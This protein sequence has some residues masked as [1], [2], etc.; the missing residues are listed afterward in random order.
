VHP[1]EG[2][3]LKAI[4][5]PRLPY[6]KRAR[7]GLCQIDSTNPPSTGGGVKILVELDRGTPETLVDARSPSVGRNQGSDTRTLLFYRRPI[8]TAKGVLDEMVKATVTYDNFTDPIATIAPVTG[9]TLPNQ[10]SLQGSHA[11]QYGSFSV[12]RMAVLRLLSSGTVGVVGPSVDLS[13]PQRFARHARV[14][15]GPAGNFIAVWR[16]NHLGGLEGR[17]V[18][19]D[20]RFS[21]GEVTRMAGQP[22]GAA[23]EVT[24]SDRGILLPDEHTSWRAQAVT[25]PGG[26]ATV[27]WVNKRSDVDQDDIMLRPYLGLPAAEWPGGPP[28]GD[29]GENL[30]DVTPDLGTVCPVRE[31]DSPDAPVDW[32][33]GSADLGVPGEFVI[34]SPQPIIIDVP[35]HPASQL[36]IDFGS[37]IGDVTTGGQVSMRGDA[38]VTWSFSALPVIDVQFDTSYLSVPVDPGA[39]EQFCTADDASSGIEAVMLGSPVDGNGDAVLV[40]HLEIP[41]ALDAPVDHALFRIPLSFSS[42]MLNCGNALVESPETCDDGNHVATDGC[43]SRCQVEGGWSCTGEPSTC[44]EICGD[45]IPTPSES[46]DD[47]NTADGDCCSSSC[48]HEASGSPCADEDVCNGEEVC[49]GNG[50]CVAGSSLD[51]D[52]GEPCT[53]DSCDPVQG[54]SNTWITGCGEAI[55]TLSAW[56]YLTLLLLVAL[57]AIAILI[58]RGYTG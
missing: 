57:A 30:D 56:G 4:A 14:A 40:G 19:G 6:Q 58:R 49:N 7:Q 50:T 55:P 53:N 37:L 29:D 23:A 54:C 27:M 8:G 44:T 11:V 20:I 26:S 45:G 48:Q 21:M 12:V 51:C 17:L 5:R 34:T 43:D 38:S 24:V 9:F 13:L 39:D 28:F 46:C 15:T 2:I 52:D 31:G 3:P 36:Q 35:D 33:P 25:N 47:G 22:Q 32:N 1:D 42:D 10:D 41:P 18:D 16:G